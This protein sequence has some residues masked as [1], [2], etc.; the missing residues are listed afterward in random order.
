[1]PGFSHRC[2]VSMIRTVHTATGRQNTSAV[3]VTRYHIMNKVES[4]QALTNI[5]LERDCCRSG[6]K[7]KQK[8]GLCTS[9]PIMILTLR[10]GPDNVSIL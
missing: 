4:Q 8:Q 3:K 9:L 7:I 10:Q 1:M 6:G 5:A 2:C